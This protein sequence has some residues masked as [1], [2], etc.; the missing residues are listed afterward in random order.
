M[1]DR[2][3]VEETDRDAVSRSQV[4][5]SGSSPSNGRVSS[6][7]EEGG[8]SGT[9]V[10]PRAK[11]ES[12]RLSSEIE[13]LL[14]SETSLPEPTFRSQLMDSD[15][16]S[17][18]HGSGLEENVLGIASR[19]RLEEAVGSVRVE[20]CIAEVKRSMASDRARDFGLIWGAR[21]FLSTVAEKSLEEIEAAQERIGGL[22]EDQIAEELEVAVT[23]SG[24]E[25]VGPWFDPRQWPLMQTVARSPDE[26]VF[27]VGL[28][29]YMMESQEEGLRKA[30]G[31]DWLEAVAELFGTV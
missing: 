21:R 14:L 4:P 5:S 19:L 2:A 3:Q 20:E 8:A 18:V 11:A 6:D 29:A 23:P 1:S 25:I 15:G 26:G 10:F 28:A 30:L 31:S 13:P 7:K 24:S 12:P 16:A 22:R 27:I 9:G 17:E